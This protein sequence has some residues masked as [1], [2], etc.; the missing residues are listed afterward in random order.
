MSI[1]FPTTKS[2]KDEI[3]NAIGQTVT[4]VLGDSYSACPVCSGLGY[5]DEINEA[6]LDSWCATCSGSYWIVGEVNSEII[7]HVRWL[8]GDQSDYGIAGESLEG[9]CIITIANDS[10]TENQIASVREIIADS[11][12]L[13]PY[14]SIYRGVPTRDRI[15]FTCRETGKE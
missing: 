12:K 10:L 5:Y 11:R 8:T 9:D 14:K 2:I 3:R 4:F 13:F 15:R 1:E 7:A 6:S